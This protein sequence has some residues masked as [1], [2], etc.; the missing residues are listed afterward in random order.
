[1]ACV[2]LF[3]LTP[4]PTDASPFSNSYSQTASFSFSLLI[5][6]VYRYVLMMCPCLFLWCL[7]SPVSAFVAAV[8]LY[9]S[10]WL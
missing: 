6:K 2:P 7:V 8:I 4:L 10:L 3:T 9:V 5:R 1:M